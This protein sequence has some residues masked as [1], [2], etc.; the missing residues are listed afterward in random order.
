M[1]VSV[2]NVKMCIVVYTN[3]MACEVLLRKT[4]QRWKTSDDG[5]E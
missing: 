5:H 2:N 3:K 1:I 4:T